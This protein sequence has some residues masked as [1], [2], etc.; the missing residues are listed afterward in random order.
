MTGLL[1][2]G[3]L[4]G[5]HLGPQ[6]TRGRA[7]VQGCG[8]GRR[9]GGAPA[10]GQE[11]RERSAPASPKG[12]GPREHPRQQVG[13]LRREPR[14]RRWSLPS[15][16]STEGPGRGRPKPWAQQVLAGA[17]AAANVGVERTF[18]PGLD[19]PPPPSCSPPPAASGVSAAQPTSIYASKV[20]EV[21]TI[22]G[23]SPKCPEHEETQSLGSARRCPVR[24]RDQTNAPLFPPSSI[25]SDGPGPCADTWNQ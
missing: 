24:G 7:H 21:G 12:A 5:I 2:G 6:T 15:A 22:Q 3:S 10:P 11:A 13:S 19:L 23:S 25:F 17:L 1:S 4:C 14:L 16:G 8:G 20:C 18:C 9:G